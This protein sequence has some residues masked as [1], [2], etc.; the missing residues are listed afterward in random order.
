MIGLGLGLSFVPQG[1]NVPAPGPTNTVAP[2]ISGTPEVGETL[3]ASTGTWTGT[4]T[5]SYAYQWQ[6][7][8]VNI[9]GATSSTYV[10]QAGDYP[11]QVRVRVT[12]TDDLGSRT[13]S[14]AAV[15]VEEVEGPAA[16]LPVGARVGIAGDS[17]MQYNN[18]ANGDVLTAGNGGELAWAQALSPRFDIDVWRRADAD[19]NVINGWYGANLGYAGQTSTT[20]LSR[21]GLMTRQQPD[22]V[23]YAAGTN[24]GVEGGAAALQAVQNAEDYA[25]GVLAA[26]TEHVLIFPVRPAGAAQSNS[27][28]IAGRLT[29]ANNISAFVAANP[30]TMTF[31]DV[32]PA[33]DPDADGVVDVALMPD[34]LHPGPT[35]AYLA[36]LDHVVPAINA[37]VEPGNIQLDNPNPE[38]APNGGLLTGNTGTMGSGVTGSVPAGWNVTATNCTVVCALAANAETGGQSLALTITPG[39]ALGTVTVSPIT[40]PAT[41]ADLWY[42]AACEVEGTTSGG[43]S[44]LT[45]SGQETKGIV[46]V[47]SD[48][49]NIRAWSI[50]PPRVANA[51]GT[52]GLSMLVENIPAGGDV[53]VVTLYRASLKL[54]ASPRLAWQWTLP[55]QTDPPTIS[56][57]ATPPVVGSVLTANDT[58]TGAVT[59]RYRWYRDG[60]LISGAT[61]STYTFAAADVGGK[62]I[63]VGISPANG[64]GRGAEMFSA[65]I[66]DG[67]A[68]TTPD[69]FTFT[70][71]TGATASTLY[72]SAPVTITGINSPSPISVTGGEY[73]IDGGS[74]TS[75]TGTI[76]SG[77][78]VEA[79]VTS[80]ATPGAS[81]NCSVTIGG[82]SDTYTVATAGESTVNLRMAVLGANITEIVN[83]DGYNYSSTSSGFSSPNGAASQQY[84]PA[85]VDGFFGATAPLKNL[86]VGLKTTQVAGAWNS[87]RCGAYVAGGNYIITGS[88]G[89]LSGTIAGAN[90]DKLRIRRAGTTVYFEIQRTGT[91]VWIEVATWTGVEN[92]NYYL[93]AYQAVAGVSNVLPF[94]SS[95]VVG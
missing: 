14:S 1:D 48:G 41:A 22:I 21:I 67:G 70:D 66:A 64:A 79:R 78:T 5:I 49:R 74:W 10:I 86:V 72:V 91:S 17:I 25:N 31:V 30:D 55:V 3:T 20:V 8:G 27:A 9:S 57:S 89:V 24:D 58:I 38:L 18:I 87:V 52:A 94:G 81:V 69:A 45:V 16:L 60:V 12:A 50:S 28:R 71:V 88:G 93:H 65:G 37:L 90:N 75:A 84:L 73:R 77:Q 32:R 47:V 61:A 4:G 29:F 43:R 7:D 6:L 44:R 82:V 51:S 95:N 46:P 36:A 92:V 80:S 59:K 40:T 39:G 34:G 26:G 53:R 83:G 56:S 54:K 85:G 63:T 76:E 33:Y 19:D 42:Q 2:S 68:D 13:T 62:A 23:A 15:T 35:G 11:G